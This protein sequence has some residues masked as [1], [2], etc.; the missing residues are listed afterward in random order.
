MDYKKEEIEKKVWIAVELLFKNDAFL[1]ENDVN[2]R[3][4]SHK[5]AEYIQTQFPEW[6]ANSI[7]LF[8]TI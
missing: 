3:S 2:E 4:V 8:N 7:F 1:L 6:H 5:L